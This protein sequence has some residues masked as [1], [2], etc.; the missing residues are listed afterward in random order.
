MTLM[1]SKHIAYLFARSAFVLG[2]ALASCSA[3]ATP[4]IDA[5]AKCYEI[6][7]AYC[8]RG[9][10][11][12]ALDPQPEPGFLADCKSMY[13]SRTDCAKYTDVVGDP[14]ACLDE[15]NSTPCSQFD[16]VNGIPL[17]AGCKPKNLFGEP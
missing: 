12:N 5:V 9:Q 16:P 4:K 14:E 11:C 3:P 6:R 17:P 8:N 7:D 13:S 2:L 1:S 10:S 15:I